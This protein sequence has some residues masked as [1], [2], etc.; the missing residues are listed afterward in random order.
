KNAMTQPTQSASGY[1]IWAV[2][3]IVYGPVELP[4]LVEW[5]KDDRV[6]A[7]TWVFC[8]A[9]DAW[10][11][12]GEV[13]ELRCHFESKEGSR[14]AQPIPGYS[15]GALR[16]IKILSELSDPQIERFAQLMEQCVVK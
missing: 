16:R 5:I 8:E 13:D 3:G 7:D 12:A 11:K 1:K 15:L 2:D 10:F 4:T 9:R 6:L 14:K